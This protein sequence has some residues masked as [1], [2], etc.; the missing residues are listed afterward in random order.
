[1][2]SQ[3]QQSSDMFLT[4]GVLGY[5]GQTLPIPK[6]YRGMRTK[7]TPAAFAPEFRVHSHVP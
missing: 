5:T 6:C 3:Y 1:M 4:S 2:A 7:L